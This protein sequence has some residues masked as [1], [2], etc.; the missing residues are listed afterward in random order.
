LLFG[1]DLNES[2]K[3]EDVKIDQLVIRFTDL[4]YSLGN[5]TVTVTD[6]QGSG[7]WG[8]ALFQVNLGFDFM[9]TYN[10]SSIEDFF[11]QST[12]SDVNNGPETFF[13]SAAFTANPP[14]N[15][16]GDP[17]AAHAPEPATMLLLGSG[18]IGLV[19]LRKK[20]KK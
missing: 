3:D 9:T 5:N 14:V 11:I 13:L 16:Y 10:A 4:T 15:P 7:N 19:G 12:I 18:L 1:L 20:F 6:Y 17:P 8:E 2:G